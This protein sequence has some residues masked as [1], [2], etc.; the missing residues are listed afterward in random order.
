[1][2]LEGKY[3]KRRLESVTAEYKKC[4]MYYKEKIATESSSDKRFMDEVMTAIYTSREC[5]VAKRFSLSNGCAVFYSYLP[6][7]ARVLYF[8]L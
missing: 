1:M 6:K 2:V 8:I 3:W 4:R 7:A 5:T